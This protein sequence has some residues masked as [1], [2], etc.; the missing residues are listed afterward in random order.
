LR[1]IIEAIWQISQ[2]NQ[3]WSV[4]DLLMK[5]EN[6][7]AHNLLTGLLDKDDAQLGPTQQ[8]FDDCLGRIQKERLKKQKEELKDQIKEAEAQG[9]SAAME[10]LRAKFQALL[11]Q[12]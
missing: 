7:D 2:D 3:M 11:K 6:A 1:E 8:V 5:I 12:D 9:N 10:E 4:N